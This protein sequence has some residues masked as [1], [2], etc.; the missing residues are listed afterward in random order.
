MRGAQGFDMTRLGSL[1]YDTKLVVPVGVTYQE[2]NHSQR[3]GNYDTTT[4][5]LVLKLTRD[6]F[7]K[8]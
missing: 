7:K 8:T 4:V 5:S 1:V 6:T 2:V 3:L